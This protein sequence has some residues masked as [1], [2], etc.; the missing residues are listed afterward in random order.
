MNRRMILTVLFLGTL[1]GTVEVFAGEALYRAGFPYASVPLSAAGLV[2]LSLGRA[3]I[4]G[5]GSSLAIGLI[6]AAYKLL[7]MLTVYA[8]VGVYACHLLGIALLAGAYDVAFS[9]PGKLSRPTRTLLA[10]Y[11]AYALFA[12]SITYVFRYQPWVQAGAGK[13]LRHIGIAGTLAAVT[14]ALVVP[15]AF[16]AAQALNGTVV[17]PAASKAGFAAAA[18][19]TVML[20]V[21]AWAVPV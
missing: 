20:W 1:W 3:R 14:G 7:A 21:L 13:I 2:I 17:R 10:V 12:V 5:A 6:A 8:D 4:D 15:P 16:R 18:L 9:V 11:G 19:A